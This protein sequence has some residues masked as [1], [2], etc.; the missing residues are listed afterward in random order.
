MKE[1]TLDFEVTVKF[2]CKNVI[3]REVY[4]KEFYEDAFDVYNFISNN[5]QE[6]ISSFGE[7]ISILSIEVV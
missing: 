1:E 5:R 4:E 2:L 3:S 7:E 6:P